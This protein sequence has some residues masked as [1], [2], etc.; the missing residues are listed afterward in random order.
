MNQ[1]PNL[2]QF[3]EEIDPN[4]SINRE[5]AIVEITTVAFLWTIK[6]VKSQLSAAEQ[7]KIDEIIKTKEKFNVGVI[8]DLFDKAGKKEPFLSS[9]N[10]NVNKVR[11]DY[12]KTHLEAMPD[13]Q[14]EKVFSKFPALKEL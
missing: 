6:E 4:K 11:T 14:R 1:I 13:D 12:I 8:Y 3:L 2:H 10:E 7:E 9:I 5:K